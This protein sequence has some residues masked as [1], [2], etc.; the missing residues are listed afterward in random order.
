MALNRWRNELGCRKKEPDAISWED[1]VT[2]LFLL[3]KELGKTHCQPPEMAFL[4]LIGL[5][6]L[7]LLK[8]TPGSLS[9]RSN[10]TLPQ[11]TALKKVQNGC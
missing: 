6:F 8:V 7:F 3:H 5:S 9:V 4:L 1:Y 11:A 10:K 2:R